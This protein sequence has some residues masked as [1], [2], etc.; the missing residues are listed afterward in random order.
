MRIMKPLIACAILKY[1]PTEHLY[2]AM[3]IQVLHESALLP[4]HVG[5]TL[6]RQA[7][8]CRPEELPETVAE[9]PVT[10]ECAASTTQPSACTQPKVGRP[11]K[12]RAGKCRL[13]SPSNMQM[14]ASRPTNANTTSCSETNMIS[15]PVWKKCMPKCTSSSLPGSAPDNM[16]SELRTKLS[17]RTPTQLFEQ[18]FSRDMFDLMARETQRYA[19]HVR[20]DVDFVTSADEMRAVV[21]IL[22]LSGYNIRSSEKD[23]WSEADD[24]KTDCIQNLMPKNRYLKLTASLHFADNSLAS[25]SYS[26][27]AFK[28]R[29]LLD[30]LNINFLQF[31]VF[32]SKLSIDEIMIRYN[33][34]HGLQ[35]FI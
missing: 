8:K 5:P 33:G 12:R 24:L 13:P 34:H 6:N 3:V 32:S 19:R 35:Q 10:V 17:E 20:N 1:R 9:Q 18:F 31:G 23:Y 30:L 14:P 16:K 7:G 25:Q 22:L 26:D 15:S 11:L 27:R 29:P 4:L 2:R 21:G 28:I